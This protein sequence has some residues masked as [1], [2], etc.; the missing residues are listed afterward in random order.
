MRKLPTKLCS[1]ATPGLPAAQQLTFSTL[2]ADAMSVDTNER[3]MHLSATRA[4]ANAV[5]CGEVGPRGR[6]EHGFLQY[7]RGLDGL[8][9]LWQSC[10]GL[11][12]VKCP[13]TGG[14]KEAGRQAASSRR[15]VASHRAVRQV[16]NHKHFL[17]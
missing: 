13:S 6:F 16:H 2:W 10:T 8:E 1:A 5:E 12:A 4:H 9:A 17:A 14:S 3:R 15:T 7:A 11:R